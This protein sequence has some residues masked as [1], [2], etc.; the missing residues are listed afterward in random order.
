[1]LA[2]WLAGT[3][4]PGVQAG[5]VR[6]PAVAGT[7]YPADPDELAQTIEQMS[8]QARK[9]PV[10]DLP[11]R[12]LKALIMPHAGYRYSGPVAA[13]AAQV[14]EGQSFSKII[15]MAPDHRVGFAKGAISDADSYR[16]PLGNVDLHADA[17]RLRKQY[18][19]FR[20]V[21][22]SDR[23]EHAV[24]VIL[25]F[26]QTWLSDFEIIPIVL[27]KNNEIES[28][29]GALETV[30]DS[31][32]LII[33]STDLS[34][35]LPYREAL[36][37]DRTTIEIITG[38]KSEELGADPRRA[39]GWKPLLVLMEIARGKQWNPRL[40]HYANSG[41]TAG[42]RDQV[43]GYATIAFYGEARMSEHE[44]NQE[45]SREKGEVLLEV[46]RKSIADRLGLK[47]GGSPVGDDAT[48][49]PVFQSNRGTF[50]TLK[51]NDQLRGCIG[52]LVPEKP[53]IEG[54]RD[55]AV[56][57]AFNDPRFGPLSPEEFSRIQIE[58]SL[59]T[60]PQPLEYTDAQD[61]LDKIRTHVDGLI[62]QK[63]A[64][65][66]TFLPQVWEQLP[67]KKSF[68]Q[69][70]C[71]KAGLPPDA[72]EKGDLQVFTYQAQYFEERD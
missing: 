35:Y 12:P 71:M 9:D 18:E 5:E 17:A 25:P 60:E 44:N 11:D 30:V 69:Q 13:R 31:N 48:R 15:I 20:P 42:R 37:R 2:I 14:L 70:L 51:I 6:K 67:D 34:H 47:T 22:A 61:L 63:G 68:L 65:S 50:V 49:D 45:I 52:N 1:M 46:A 4:A 59:L 33:V 66:A 24:E 55:N 41:D 62:I 57:A 36:S 27:G 28:Y 32:T 58:V 16:T 26:L 29:A 10:K 43:V 8:R 38:M 56:N 21:A 39:C 40:L 64:R 7:F 23:R 19:M 53:L 54:V 72:W 3:P